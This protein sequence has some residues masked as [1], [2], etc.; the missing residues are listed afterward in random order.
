MKQ[1]ESV[2]GNKLRIY[3]EISYDY[4]KWVLEDHGRISGKNT[5]QKAVSE[6]KEFNKGQRIILD[7]DKEIE[8]VQ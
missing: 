5:K 1:G 7:F 6:Y 2:F 3:T 8:K 4:V